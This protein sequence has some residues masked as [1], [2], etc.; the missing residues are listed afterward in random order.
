ME[1]S[2]LP[3]LTIQSHRGP[4]RVRLGHPFEGLETGLGERSHL[5]IDARIAELYGD[6]LAPALDGR[7]VLRIEATEASKSLERLPRYVAH[8][9][10]HGVRRD[11]VLVA[12]GGGVIQDITAFIA[13]TLLRGVPWRFYPTT[14]LAQA[15]SCIGSK[16][17]INVG[18]YKNQLGTFVPPHEIIIATEVLDTLS[19][20]DVRSGIGEII[21][22]HIISGWADTRTLAA[23]YPRLPKEKDVLARYIFGAL[24]IKKAKIEIDEFD[25]GERLVMN[26]GHTFGHAI[27]TATDYGVPHGIAVTIGMDLANH[28]SL[29]LGFIEQ[30]VF[31][32]LH[33]LLATNYCGFEETP[34]P[35]DRF[36]AA[37][38]K[39]KK[40]R[41][42][43]LSLVLMRGPGRVFLDRYAD[44][45]RLRAWCGDYFHA[46][47]GSGRGGN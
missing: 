25:R 3:D 45:R 35:A 15:D 12:V 27:E 6:V 10:E 13:A 5:I 38:G 30:A 31:D 9:I 32:E 19:E 1:D 14:V 34:I 40:N 33:R 11:H 23:D 29:Q 28:L 37:L 26:Y 41:D 39:D 22:T 8:L 43:D 44:D 21:K 46:V 24:E 20:T 47:L 16:S 17:S 4:Y 36:F 7:S 18:P 42:G 2:P